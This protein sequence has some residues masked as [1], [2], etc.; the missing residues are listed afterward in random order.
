MA[1]T[2]AQKEYDEMRSHRIAFGH[3]ISKAYHFDGFHVRFPG[4]GAKEWEK[5]C[6]FYLIFSL[7]IPSDG[8]LQIQKKAE[9]LDYEYN[10]YASGNHNFIMKFRLIKDDA[11]LEEDIEV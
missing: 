11:K 2:P 8:I 6:D 7:S 9:E 3:I 4:G 1:I 10:L 5:D